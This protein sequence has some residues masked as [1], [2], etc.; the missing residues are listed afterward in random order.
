MREDGFEGEGVAGLG[1]EFEVFGMC[2]EGPGGAGGRGG[3]EGGDR[4]GDFEG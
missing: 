3:D 4:D 1:F 2:D